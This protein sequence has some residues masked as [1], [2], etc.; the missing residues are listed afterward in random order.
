MKEV[1]WIK[2]S[3]NTPRDEKIRKLKRKNKEFPWIWICLLTLA[4]RT[5]ENGLIQFAEGIPYTIADL[6]DY[7]GCQ[8][9][10]MES[11]IAAMYELEM[12]GNT[13]GFLTIINWEKYQN[14]KSLDD[15]KEDNRIRKQRQRARQKCDMS[16]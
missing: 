9:R 16:R 8:A 10:T 12:L 2:L 7:T 14:V 15:V 13:E 11:A 5:N 3:V 4:G 6:A 1:G